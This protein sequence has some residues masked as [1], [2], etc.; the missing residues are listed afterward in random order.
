MLWIQLLSVLSEDERDFVTRI[1]EEFGEKMY[2][3]ALS[4]LKN[5]DDAQN[6]VS[7]IMYAIIRNIDKYEGE[8]DKMIRNQIVIHMN[9]II[10]NISINAYNKRSRGTHRKGHYCRGHDSKG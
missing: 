9:S 4:M 10:R 7:D 6:A 1:Y 5:P 8:G 3:S 2:N